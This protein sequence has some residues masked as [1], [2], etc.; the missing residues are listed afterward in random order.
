MTLEALPQ[1]DREVERLIRDN[2]GLV[3]LIARRFKAPHPYDHDDL[4]EAGVIGLIE[5]AKRWDARDGRATFASYAGLRVRGAIVDWIR[6][7]AWGFNRKGAQHGAE[8]PRSLDQPVKVNGSGGEN[9]GEPISLHTL[10]PAPADDVSDPDR[11]RA[12]A[13]LLP[14][15][16]Y[17]VLAVEQGYLLWE[18]GEQLGVTESR[19]SQILTKARLRLYHRGHLAA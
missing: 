17:V 1:L 15:E 5:A 13:V 6:A 2:L 14:R 19:V 3:H 10:I 4:Y 12:L 9:H 16:R 18:I 7:N 11:T 8:L